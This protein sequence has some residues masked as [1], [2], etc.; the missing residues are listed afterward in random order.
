MPIVKGLVLPAL[1]A[2]V[3]LFTGTETHQVLTASDM[4]DYHGALEDIGLSD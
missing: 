2:S 4:L 3:Y 1:V